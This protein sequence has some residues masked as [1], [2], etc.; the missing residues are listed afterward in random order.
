MTFIFSIFL[1]QMGL[2]I[3]GIL[4]VVTSVRPWSLLPILPLTGVLIV[5]RRFYMSS[6]RDIKRLEGVSKSPVFSQ[7]STSLRGLTTIRAL[8]GQQMLQEEFDHL[9]DIHTS[10]WFAFI[11]TT[12]WFGLWLDWIVTV[13]MACV[14]YSF[15]LLSADLLDGEVGL[16]ISSCMMLEEVQWMVRQTAEVENL[17]TSV[18]RVMEYC[19]LKP[20]DPAHQQSSQ[21]R[22]SIG[23][24]YHKKS[25]NFQPAPEWPSEGQV[26]FEDVGLRYHSEGGNSSSQENGLAQTILIHGC[27]TTVKSC[28]PRGAE[29]AEFLHKTS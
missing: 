14:V 26:Q 19:G 28:R 15:L 16:A 13:Y 25:S 7:L 21:G 3:V 22:N 9:Q 20:E 8:D 5:L 12:R 11:S 2:T 1:A 29:A 10:T 4:A 18:E 17:M 6:S 23:G 24:D 27:V